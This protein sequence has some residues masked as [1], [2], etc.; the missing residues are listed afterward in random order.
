MPVS[1]SAGRNSTC[2][3]RPLQ[4]PKPDTVVVRAIV[5]CF[6]SACIKDR[7]LSGTDQ[8]TRSRGAAIAARSTLRPTTPGFEVVRVAAAA[9]S[10]QLHSNSL[11]RGRQESHSR[12][13]GGRV[14]P[15]W[16]ASRCTRLEVKSSDGCYG[17]SRT[18]FSERFNEE[19][20][21]A[22]ERR[23]GALD[24]LMLKTSL[25]AVEMCELA[26]H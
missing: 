20:E 7:L 2:T 4:N 19:G 24:G 10:C 18:D 14:L 16:S 5:R 9:R 1:A 22:R 13:P 21:G 17:L 12:G 15:V 11:R 3:S 25:R 26:E 23:G 8:R 6:R